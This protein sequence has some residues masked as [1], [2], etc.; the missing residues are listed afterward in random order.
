MQSHRS[1]KSDQ[2]HLRTPSRGGFAARTAR[3]IAPPSRRT[4]PCPVCRCTAVRFD[5]VEAAD[6]LHLAECPR[7]EHRWTSTAPIVRTH[8]PRGRVAFVR[9]ARLDL[10]AQA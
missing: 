6:V 8:A 10:A 5:E 7:C 4:A 9:G 3:Q 1:V 2:L